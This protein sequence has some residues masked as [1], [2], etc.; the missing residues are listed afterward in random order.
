MRTSSDTFV[1]TREDIIK[2]YNRLKTSEDLDVLIKDIGDAKYVLLGEASHGTHEY[3]TW[4][5]AISKRL[6]KEKGFSFIAVEGDWPDCYRINRFVKGYKD[7]GAIAI[8]VLREFRRWPTWMLANWEIAAL[9]EWMRDHN[10]NMDP[11]KKIGFYGL[12]VYS[13]WESL[14]VMAKYLEKEDPNAGKLVMNAVK[15]FEPYR[16][17]MDK[18]VHDVYT[19]TSS[20][21]QEVVNLLKEVRKKAVMYNGDREAG[22]NAEMNAQI[23]VNAE[24]YYTSMVLFGEDSWNVRDSHMMGTLNSLMEFHGT[25]AKAI[26]WEHNTHV[27]DARATDMKAGGLYN[28]G[29]LAREQHAGDGVFIVGFGSY[30]GSVIA[31]KAWGSEMQKT[32]VPKA[33]GGSIEDI[34]HN[35]S[36]ENKLLIFSNKILKDH[37]NKWLGHRAIGVVYHPERELG[38]YVPTLLSSRYD[39]FIFLDKTKALYPLHIQPDGH[40]EPETYPFGF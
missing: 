2:N 13:L 14:D 31:G 18:Y 22:L 17:E 25:E 3:Y 30:E 23:A 34:L 5:T 15:C 33:M 8:E 21:R 27:G 36:K 6:I 10:Q 29:Q 4:R 1:Y 24:K 12:D 20:C 9:A 7:S 39:A 32:E 11:E 19:M 28:V 16:E 37:F 35:D 40:L 26:V 38:N